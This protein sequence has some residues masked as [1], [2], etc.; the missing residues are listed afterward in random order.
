MVFFNTTKGPVVIEI[1]PEEDGHSITGNIDDVWQ[2][3]LEDA[4][5]AGAD[6]GKGGKYLVLPPGYTDKIPDG[7]IALHALTYRGYAL[8]RSNLASHADADVAGSLA[9][10]KRIKAYDFAQSAN[11]PATRFTD[12]VDNL[13]DATIPYDER[14][15]TSLNRVVQEE[16]WLDRDRVMIDLLK[17]IGIEKGKPFAPDAATKALYL[18]AIQDAHAWLDHLYETTFPPYWPTSRWAVPARA[19]HVAAFSNGYADPD[20]YPVDAR[21]T[22]YTLGYVGI[23]RLG[24]G[25]FYLISSKDK[26]G[27]ALDGNATYRL[28]VP[29]DAPVQLYWSATAYDRETHALIKNMPRASRA[30]N[31]AE[32]QKNAD[33]STDIY[34]G[35]SAPAGKESNWVPTDPARQFELLFRLYAPTKPLFDK[36][37][38]LPDV[39]KATG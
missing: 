4:G 9:Y 5:P 26:D 2:M 30:S 7:Y 12:A 39:E 1:P 3:P 24:V 29:A 18:A 14:F 27:D 25:Q 28:H 20:T 38:T 13:F 8:I 16:P 21:S 23:K 11:P 19:E 33:G 22:T 32:I 17:S 37:W 35:P 10:G 6:E 31:A 34:F 36:T 15:F